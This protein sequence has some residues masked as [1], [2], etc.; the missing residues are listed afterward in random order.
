V[1]QLIEFVISDEDRERLDRLVAHFGGSRSGYL[2]ATLTVMES[3]RRVWRLR[4][5]QAAHDRRLTE[6]GI[7]AEQLPDLIRDAYKTSTR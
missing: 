5:L 3:L 1:S 7:S 2:R 4:A 6:H